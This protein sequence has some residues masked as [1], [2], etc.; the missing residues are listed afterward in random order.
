MEGQAGEG[1]VESCGFSGK[2]LEGGDDLA[3]EEGLDAEDAFTAV[4][5][6]VVGEL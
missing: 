2:V 1:R 3:G 4:V 5:G 6:C